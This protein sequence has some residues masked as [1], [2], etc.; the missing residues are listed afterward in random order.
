MF[1]ISQIT[2][3]LGASLGSN[4]NELPHRRLTSFV[5]LLPP[6]RSIAC[7]PTIESRLISKHDQPIIMHLNPA[8]AVTAV[9]ISASVWIER[10]V[11]NLIHEA[12][13]CWVKSARELT[14]HSPS[15][16]AVWRAAKS[17]GIV[18]M[19]EVRDITAASY[20]DDLAEYERNKMQRMKDAALKA[21]PSSTHP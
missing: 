15:A 1:A 12:P 21:E 7:S 18:T 11:D 4:Q 9:C 14:I 13:A 6:T 20:R 2:P 16:T 5:R 8:L 17:D 10:Q 3:T 19:A